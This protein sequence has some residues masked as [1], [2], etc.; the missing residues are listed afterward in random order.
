[1]RGGPIIGYFQPVEIEPPSGASVSLAAEGTFTEPYSGAAEVGLLIGA[2]YRLRVSELPGYEGIEI[3]PT[4]EVIDRVYPPAGQERRFP[5][6]IELTEQDLAL[7]MEGKFVTRVIYV[8]DPDRAL[9]KAQGEQQEWFD[10]GPGENPLETADSLGRPVA[11]VRIGGRL[12][13]DLEYPD[14]EFLGGCPP[15]TV[16]R[17]YARIDDGA[18]WIPQD[19]EGYVE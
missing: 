14:Y 2:V 3:F 7:A 6:P 16:F 18:D 5:I 12:P 13:N 11:I 10:V 9:P 1:M 17:P 4:I 8:E 15:F 19:E